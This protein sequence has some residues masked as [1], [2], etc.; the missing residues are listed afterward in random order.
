[1]GK[2]YDDL[3]YGPFFDCSMVFQIGLDDSTTNYNGNVIILQLLFR[4]EPP[5]NSWVEPRKVAPMALAEVTRRLQ[6]VWVDVIRVEGEE[7]FLVW[8]TCDI[9]MKL[10]FNIGNVLLGNIFFETHIY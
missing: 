7:V 10:L 8:Y 4:A 3:S 1:M 2:S 5:F 9:Y 6:P